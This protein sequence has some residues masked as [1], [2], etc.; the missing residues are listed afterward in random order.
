MKELILE[1]F[2]YDERLGRF[3]HK[4]GD[5]RVGYTN[6]RG[7]R[8]V[9]IHGT[10]YLESDLVWFL[11]TGASPETPLIH[12]NGKKTNNRFTNLSAT[13]TREDLK[14]Q[15]RQVKLAAREKGRQDKIEALETARA[16]KRKAKEAAKEAKRAAK[17]AKKEAKRKATE[18]RRSIAA[19][20]KAA[21]ARATYRKD[22]ELRKLAAAATGMI[23]HEPTP[24]GL[25]HES[26]LE[27]IKFDETEGRFRYLP[28]PDTAFAHAKFNK[29]YA[30]QLAGDEREGGYRTIFIKG[31]RYL[32][33]DIA[34]FF[35]KRAWPVTPIGHY[36]GDRLNIRESNLG[37]V[38]RSVTADVTT[39]RKRKNT[40]NTAGYAGVTW[41]NKRQKFL[42]RV[43]RGGKRRYGGAFDDVHLAGAKATA[44]Y[45]ALGLEDTSAE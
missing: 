2:D 23:Q 13:L 9:L 30:G 25:T 29:K 15:A 41:C 14:Q 33:R 24:A 6:I 37:V 3:Y 32:E 44:M 40:N 11:H 21:K 12:L 17:E 43:C 26:L 7:E 36:D 45:K 8:E 34:W 42:V 16:A 35:F 18:K 22:T 20:R 27:T 38:D 5:K 28:R 10:P 4:G 39:T 31:K 1:A 19:E